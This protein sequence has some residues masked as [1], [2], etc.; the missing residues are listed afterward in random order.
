MA[1]TAKQ[2]A[3][4]MF[5]TSSPFTD[6]QWPQIS[7]QDQDILLDLICNLITPLGDHRRNHIHPSKGKKRKRP[8]KA[9]QNDTTMGEAPPPP[10][11]I[12]KHMLIGLNSVTRHLEALAARNGPST[13]PFATLKSDEK[14]TGAKKAGRQDVESGEDSRPLSM[15]ILTHPKPSLS[16]AHAH[17]PTLVHLSTLSPPSTPQSPTATTRLIPLATSTDGRLASKLHIPRV[18]ALGIFQDAPGAKALE[19]F[20]RE[21]IGLTECVWIDEAMKA[22]WRG[23]NVKTEASGSHK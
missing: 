4:A 10:P 13:S 19:D 22:D 2:S 21:N 1:P 20:V 23:V 7:Q 17:L 3:K 12:G 9:A 8:C 16:P 11:E 18:G 5:K 14:E 15:V 6:T